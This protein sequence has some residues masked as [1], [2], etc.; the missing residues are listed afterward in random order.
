MKR[1][2]KTYECVDGARLQNLTF[3]NKLSAIIRKKKNYPAIKTGC[4][5]R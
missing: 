3:L 1:S 5:F 2:T 4:E